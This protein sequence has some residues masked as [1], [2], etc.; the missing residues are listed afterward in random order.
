MPYDWAKALALGLFFRY[1]Q[2][3][4]AGFSYSYGERMVRFQGKMPF[5]P[6]IPGS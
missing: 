6:A 2:N 1:P 4:A 3:R 5:Y